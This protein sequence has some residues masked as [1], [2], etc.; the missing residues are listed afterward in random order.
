[1]NTNSRFNNITTR[2]EIWDEEGVRT[3]T[4]S[5]RFKSRLTQGSTWKMT[6]YFT[7][8]YKTAKKKR[9]SHRNPEVKVLILR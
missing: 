1:M 4:F 3:L 2:F 8:F 6:I 9:C 5:L 7:I